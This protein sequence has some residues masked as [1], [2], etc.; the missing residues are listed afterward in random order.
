MLPLETAAGAG[1]TAADA[2]V[3]AARDSST[4]AS[5]T[6]KRAILF[7]NSWTSFSFDC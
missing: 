7:K 6:N 3:H 4:R 2:A 5:N 1:G